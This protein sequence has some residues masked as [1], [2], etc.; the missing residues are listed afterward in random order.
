MPFRFEDG[1][2]PGDDPDRTVLIEEGCSEVEP[3]RLLESWSRHLLVWM[4]TLLE[5]GMTKV[6][7]DWRSR[8]FNLGE[9]V[10]VTLP[11][12]RAV[13]HIRRS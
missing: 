9:D 5:D 8:A 11:F 10:T 7:A 4:N 12:R 3:V 1:Q 13:R 2:Q 6:H